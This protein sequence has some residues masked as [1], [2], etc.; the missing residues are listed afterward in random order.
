MGWI[1]SVIDDVQQ[2]PGEFPVAM[3][4]L[5]TANILSNIF[6]WGN[7]FSKRML[8]QSYVDKVKSAKTSPLDR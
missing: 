6:G 2:Q 4:P 5:G 7:T 1:F 3:M 8:K